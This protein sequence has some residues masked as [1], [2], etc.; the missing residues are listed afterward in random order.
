MVKPL[1]F[2]EEVAVDTMHL[3]TCKGTK[4]TV[5]SMLDVGSGFHLVYPVTGRKGGDYVGCFLHA[6]MA[7]AGTPTTVLADQEAGLTRDFPAE[8]EKHGINVQYT[9][10][11]AHW[12]NGHVERQNEWF[13]QMFDRVKEHTSM[14]EH[15]TEWVLAAVGEA[16]NYLRRRHGYSPAQWLFGVTPR[17]GIGLAEGDDD[18]AERQDLINPSED[19]QR[20][21]SIRQAAREAYIQ[22]QASESLQRALHGRPRVLRGDFQQGQYVY[23]Y[24]TSKMAGG[25]A[26]KRQNIGEWI[27]PGIVVGQEGKNFWVSRGGRCLLCAREHLRLAESE[28]L[29]AALQ[30]RA[31]KKDLMQLIEGME[32]D[33]PEVFADATG[34]PEPHQSEH[35]E[36]DYTPTEPD[37][38]PPGDDEGERTRASKREAEQKLVPVKRMRQKGD[39]PMVP[40]NVPVP[41]DDEL[42]CYMASSDRVPRALQKQADKELK[43]NQIPEDEIPLYKEAEKKQWGEHLKYQAIKILPAHIAAEVRKR[44]PKER[45]LRARFAYRDKNCAKRR[46]DPL[47]PAKAKARLCVGGHRDPDLKT[48]QLNTEAPTATKVSITCLVFLTVQLG[49][50]LAAGDIEAAFLNGVEARR[51]LYFEPPSTGLEGVEEGSLIEIVKGVFGLSTSP[52]LWWDKLAGTLKDI[53]I[54]YKGMSLNLEQHYL[55]SCLFLLVNEEKEIHGLLATHVDDIL[56]SAQLD[57]RRKMEEA[58]SDVFPIDTWDDAKDGLE[59]CGVSIKQSADEISLSQEHYVNTRLQTVDIPKGA[60]LK[61]KA[62]EVATLGLAS[63]TRPDIQAGVSM[64]QRKQK[65]PTYEDIQDTNQVVHMAQQ[66]KDEK[67]TYTKLG[68]FSDLILLVYHDAAWANIPENAE[69]LDDAVQKDTDI[70]SQLG[71]ITLI[72]HKNILE[73]KTGQGLV[74]CWKSHACPRVCRST[75][76]AETMAALEGWES[77]IAFRAVLLGCFPG[78]GHKI[79]IVSLTDCKPFYDSVYRIGGPRAPPEKRLMVDLAAIRQIIQEEESTWQL[80][81]KT[82]FRKALHWLPTSAQMSGNLTRVI[83]KT[84]EWWGQLKELKPAGSIV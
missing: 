64:A 38:G 53:K 73:G 24:R 12:Q 70:Y 9:A 28:E 18:T 77:A 55:D 23:I 31:V 72:A 52:R 67:L 25:V 80:E 3:Y 20:R 26:R 61:G 19:W 78:M 34:D 2:N 32:V 7:W 44:V 62:D 27:G 5:L 1:D 58:L 16:K 21:A 82:T 13:R 76:A 29:G 49:W 4:V 75:F 60:D 33:D 71:H 46:E 6:W 59:Y 56:I 48:G 84:K 8:L 66:A 83:P 17:L 35:P 42:L 57:L 54:E 74:A 14:Q 15:E 10:G 68:N 37:D 43:W 65:S 36:M 50:S 81:Q 11:Q 51:D 40:A 63:Q 39:V 22:L 69:N 41:E 30:A 79:P 45:I 47:V